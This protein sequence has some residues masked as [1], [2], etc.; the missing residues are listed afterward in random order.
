MTRYDTSRFLKNEETGWFD[1]M[2]EGEKT[3]EIRRDRGGILPGHTVRF[4]NGS[5]PE[6]G[7]VLRRVAKVKRTTPSKVKDEELSS[8]CIQREWLEDY[9]DGDPVYLFFLEADNE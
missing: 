3:I 5:D 1:S 4:I 6:R 2:L 8:A 7:T 9:A